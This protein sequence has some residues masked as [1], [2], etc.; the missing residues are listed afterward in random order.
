MSL[1]KELKSLLGKKYCFKQYAS[2][3]EVR[4]LKKINPPDFELMTIAELI[5]GMVKIEASLY[6]LNG[7]L[8]LVYDV[9]VK[10]EPDTPEWIC[11]DSP[12]DIVIL[13]ESAMLTVLDRVVK[14][15]ELSYTECCFEKIDGR[16]VK[17]KPSKRN[18]VLSPVSP[19]VAKTDRKPTEDTSGNLN[20]EETAL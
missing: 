16:L 7:R 15:K 9:F 3:K 17:K 13:K 19:C 2:D 5:V 18:A 20:G 1:K 10:D 8:Q 4:R 11:Y 14:E 6:K 12:A